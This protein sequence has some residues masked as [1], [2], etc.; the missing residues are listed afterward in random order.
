MKKKLTLSVIILC[1]RDDERLEKA[2]ASV[3]F[4]DQVILVETAGNINISRLQKKYGCEKKSLPG[5]T[6]PIDFSELRNQSLK[7]AKHDWVF[8]LDSDEVVTENSIPSF[9]KLIEQNHYEA[10]YIRRYDFFHG[11][12]LRWGEL[13]N[14]WLLRVGKKQ[15]LRYLRPV[16]EV[17]K[18]SS[19]SLY[20]D[21][22]L[23]HQAHLSISEFI[24]K[25]T[26]YSR[27]EARYRLYLG[28]TSSLLEAILYPIA[29]FKVNYFFKLGFL[30]GWR[31][32]V[33][34][35]VMSLHSFAVRVSLYE[36]HKNQFQVKNKKK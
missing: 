5:N 6:K 32:F 15:T 2:V 24:D 34:A 13:R 9:K 27:I 17:A 20:A 11:K 7:F 28:E 31:G 33:Y 12:Q 3:Q 36:L 30:D 19:T 8:F 14:V 4:S 10:A 21:I 1:H 22:T 16:H 29:K 35:I 23:H 18:L 26:H 25:I